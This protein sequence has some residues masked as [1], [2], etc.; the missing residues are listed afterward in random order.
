MNNFKIPLKKIII[1]YA[2]RSG[3]FFIHRLL[4]GHSNIITFHPEYDLYVYQTL[5][6]F[7]CK[8]LLLSSLPNYL[9]Q[10]LNTKFK[11]NLILPMSTKIDIDMNE[12]YKE[13]DNFTKDKHESNYTLDLL[14]DLFYFCHSIKNLNYINKTDPYVLIQT[15]EAFEDDELNFFIKNVNLSNLILM[16]RDPVKSLDS[17]YYHLK[18][19][20][21]INI[22]IKT[23]FTRILIDFSKSTNQIFFCL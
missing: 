2:G 12:I 1:N 10:N 22:N 13:I 15:H 9:Y 14:I 3:S 5:R 23:L 21:N 11:Q 18:N 16:L 20:N 7:F 19:E 8:K 6:E 4:D 17:H